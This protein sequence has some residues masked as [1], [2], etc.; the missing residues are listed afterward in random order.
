MTM[1]ATETEGR[2]V[3]VH[4]VEIDPWNIRLPYGAPR[5]STRLFQ[6]SLKSTCAR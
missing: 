6:T 5:Y 3:R 1:S 4:D 2:N